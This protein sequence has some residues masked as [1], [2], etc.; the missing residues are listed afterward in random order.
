MQNSQE[1]AKIFLDASGEIVVCFLASTTILA[2]A[3]IRILCGA[4]DTTGRNAATLSGANGVATNPSIGADHANSK[5]CLAIIAILA[6]ATFRK[7]PVATDT[8]GRNAATLSGAN[9][10]TTNLSRGAGLAWCSVIERHLAIIAI[11]ANATFRKLPVATDT[12]GI[13]A[14]TLSGANVV[15]TK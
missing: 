12:A 4:A 3:S 2:N 15:A 7:L 6:N 8:F 1:C 11:L 9:G 13:N 10:V 5:G 14:A